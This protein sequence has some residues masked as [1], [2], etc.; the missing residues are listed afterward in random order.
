[1]PPRP[2]NGFLLVFRQFRR[3]V[4]AIEGLTSQLAAIA[5]QQRELGPALD[6]VAL[7]ETERHQFKAEVEGLLLRAE[8]KLKAAANAEARERQLKK[9]YERDIDPFSEDG[10]G[11]AQPVDGP[12]LGGDAPASEAERMQPLRLDVA[13]NN[14]AL[15][16]RAKWGV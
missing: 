6:R 8:G 7:L 13:P 11:Q 12:V 4:D 9:S 5:E 10:N 16:Q 2:G 15:A 3:L 14:K 1:V